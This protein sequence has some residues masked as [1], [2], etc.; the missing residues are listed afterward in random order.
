[1]K[2]KLRNTIRFR[3]LFHLIGQDVTLLPAQQR[4]L[5]IGSVIFANSSRES[6]ERITAL[7]R[8]GWRKKRERIHNLLLEAAFGL[9]IMI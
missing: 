3:V 1:M 9:G 7:N 6:L 5:T 2:L 4:V 8:T